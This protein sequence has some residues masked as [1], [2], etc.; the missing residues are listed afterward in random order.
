MQKR[1]VYLVMM[2]SMEDLSIKHL[3]ARMDRIEEIMAS[4]HREL[5]WKFENLDIKYVTRR[6]YEA[7][8]DTSKG[9]SWIR[10]MVISMVVS[11][12]L[13]LIAIFKLK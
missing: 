13:F 6:E 9:I 1:K 11:V 3:E 5:L 7:T 10:Q 8:K 12:W 2:N 4:N